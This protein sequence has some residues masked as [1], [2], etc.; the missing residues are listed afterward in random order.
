MTDL[1]HQH[2]MSHTAPQPH[3]DILDDQAEWVIFENLLQFNTNMSLLPTSQSVSTSA[4][5]IMPPQDDEP[6]PLEAH[7]PSALHGPNAQDP[8][9]TST[10]KPPSYIDVFVDDFVG[11]SQEYCNSRRI[12]QIILHVIDDVFHPLYPSDTSFCQKHTLLKTLPKGDCSWSTIKL[13]LGWVIDTVLM[14][15]HTPPHH[16]ECPAEISSSIPI[17]QKR[18]N[19]KNDKNSLVSSIWWQLHFLVPITYSVKCNTLSPTSSRSE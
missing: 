17:T 6:P 9:L 15:I 13:V 19:I 18:N 4:P 5:T 1:A 3:H 12:R 14:T 16:L 8:S 7:T 11:L 2:I 10:V